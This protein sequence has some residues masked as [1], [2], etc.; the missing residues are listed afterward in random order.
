RCQPCVRRD[1]QAAAKTRRSRS[2]QRRFAGSLRNITAKPETLRTATATATLLAPAPAIKLLRD[3]KVEKGDALEIARASGILAAK[4]T[5][6]LLP[7]CHQLPLPGVDIHYE[8]GKT[9]VGIT[10]RV[11]TISGTGVEMEAL[12]AASVAALTIY[13]LLKPHAGN[14][15]RIGD[16]KL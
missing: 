15:M 16:V 14:V 6:D 7:L 11:K 8:L 3:K 2:C 9:Q 10:V 12:T 1:R 4:R 5:W 13:D